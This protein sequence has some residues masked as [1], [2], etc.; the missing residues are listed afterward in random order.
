VTQHFATRQLRFFLT[1]PSPCPY[2][3]GRDERKVFAHLPLTEGATVNDGLTQVGFRRSQNIAY[4]PAC[5]ACDACVSARI[6]VNGYPFGRSERRI[7]DRSA[8]LERH[9]VEAEATME[10]FD[11][12][13]RYLSARHSTGGMADMTWPDYVAMVED[14][15]V[16]THLVEYRKPSGDQ[17]PGELIAC[18]LV[19]ILHDGLSLVYSFYDPGQGRRSLGSFAILDHVE[20]A[21]GAGIP[22]VYLGYWVSGS[23]KMAYK[24]RFNPLEVLKPGGWRLLSQRERQELAPN[25]SQ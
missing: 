5:D 15:A 20:Q 13:R 9:L 21:Q 6:P 25:H 24:A 16:R 4:R 1:A 23:V 8:D 12:L 7:L 14:T 22:Y 2:L 19:D 17:G 10:Q 11:L 18:V 3:P